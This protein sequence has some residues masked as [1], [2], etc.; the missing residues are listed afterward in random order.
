MISLIIPLSRSDEGIFYVQLSPL[1]M[2]HKI[3]R[4]LRVFHDLSVEELSDKLDIP[5][6][7]IFQL[8][9]GE[10]VPELEIL[11]KYADFS[12]IPLFSLL[13]F[14][15]SLHPD[16]VT[17]KLRIFIAGKVIALLNLIATT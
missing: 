3:L 10:Q 12:Q 14:T 2:L 5:K 17:E 8:E 16:S 15:E 6:S 7:Y 9:S 4:S 13:F 11:G 1:F